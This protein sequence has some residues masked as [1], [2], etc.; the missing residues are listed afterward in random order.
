MGD[1]AIG[2]TTMKLLLDGHTMYRVKG[3][4]ER[5]LQYLPDRGIHVPVGDFVP[6]V[7]LITEIIHERSDVR[8]LTITSRLTGNFYHTTPNDIEEMDAG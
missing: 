6:V 3:Q 7:G 8:K 2:E 1:Y 4:Q 5:A